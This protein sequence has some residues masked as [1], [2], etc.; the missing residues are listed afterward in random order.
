M[1][2]AEF[3]A[4]WSKDPRT[5]VGAVLVG[6]NR[7]HIAIAYNGFPPGVEDTEER[8]SDRP[9]KYF[10]MQHA[11]RNVLDNARFDTEGATLYAT[12]HPCAECAKSIVSKKIAAVACPSPPSEEPWAASAKYAR[13][14]LEE[15]GVE[16]IPVRMPY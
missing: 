11:E 9:T 1:D 7:N 16:I 14:I 12:M 5:K 3:V 2:L 10:F 4:L 6:K 13:V 8:L 15:A